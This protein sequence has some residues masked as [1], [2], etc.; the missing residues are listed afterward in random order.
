MK[1]FFDQNISPKIAKQLSDI[2][3]D[4]THVRYE[5]FQ[6]AS[7]IE[8]FEYA[9]ANNLTIVTF[10]ADFVDI[11]VVRGIPPKIIWLKTGNLTT[12][13]ISDLL[14]RNLMDI[15]KFLASEEFEILELIK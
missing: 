11:N 14:N 6:D 3:P 13:S 2:F 9:K 10:D 12:K 5:G 15:E 7:D 4:S 8:I 1:L